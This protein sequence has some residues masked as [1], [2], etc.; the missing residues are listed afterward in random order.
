MADKTTKLLKQLKGNIPQNT[1]FGNFSLP[2][3]SGDHTR[4]TK[5]DAPSA[6]EDLANKKYVDDSTATPALQAV[7]DVGNTTTTDINC[8]IINTST[9]SD[10]VANFESTTDK[11]TLQIN[12]NDT[13]AY[14][15]VKNDRLQ[16]GAT[17]ALDT[18]NISINL[19]NGRLG[20]GKNSPSNPLHVVNA[21]ADT[22]AVFKSEDDK[23]AIKISDDD[24]DSFWGVRNSFAYF[25]GTNGL[26]AANVNFD[27]A[28][29][30]LGVGTTTPATTLDVDGDLTIDKIYLN[31]DIRIG[32][33]LDANIVLPDN[34][35]VQHFRIK[36]SD[37][38]SV[39]MCDS[40][41]DVTGFG[42]WSTSGDITS[43]AG[44]VTGTGLFAG[45]GDI[46]SVPWTDY[47]GTS[48]IVGWQAVGLT[49]N[50]WY[51]KIGK[52]VYVSYAITGTSNAVTASFTLPYTAVNSAAYA[53]ISAMRFVDNGVASATPG[54]ASLAANQA[55]VNLWVDW[56]T[57]ANWTNANQKNINGQFF[58]EV[59]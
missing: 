28:N 32:T 37:F 41:G 4:G 13:T 51:K 42:G 3:T 31:D 14:I 7:C 27:I 45:T 21:T 47:S 50:I 39:F 22:L 49:A 54:M 29:V 35:G 2:N 30:R 55:V 26:N 52:L 25:G 6:N 9:A 40:N 33:N 16:L 5:R 8:N 38:N 58:Y 34:A 12:D 24:T 11:A 56:T 48:T 44:D 1:S 36:D 23:A 19:D 10:V 43:T 46:N 57:L 53:P 20:I 18:G 59:A 17:N 15:L